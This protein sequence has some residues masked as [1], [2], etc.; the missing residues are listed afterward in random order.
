MMID[1]AKSD[2]AA[3]LKASYEVVLMLAEHGKA[4]WD[5]KII[6]KCATKLV[7]AFSDEN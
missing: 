1:F 5:G 6:K 2:L 4:F 7:L 3:D